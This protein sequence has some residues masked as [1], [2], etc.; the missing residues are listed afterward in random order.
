MANR[1]CG[2]DSK[3]TAGMLREPVTFERLTRTSDGA[4]GFTE[5]WAAI[6]GAP[7]LAAV[8]PLSGRERWASQRIE[9][10]A[11][12]RVA[13]R[14]F[15]GLTEVDRVVIRDRPCQIR[16]ISNLNMADEWLEIDVEMGVAA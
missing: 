1:C 15:D 7:T 14:Y 16:F 6:A 8:K 12:Y 3:Y 11:N 2:S 13:V 5:G 9:A 4:G 10:T